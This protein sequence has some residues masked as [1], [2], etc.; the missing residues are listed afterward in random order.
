MKSAGPEDGRLIDAFLR[1]TRR[2]QRARI[3]LER[4]L[5]L[6]SPLDY[7]KLA[8]QLPLALAIWRWRQLTPEAFAGRF[9]SPL[10][11]RV[12]RH[13][14]SPLLYEMITLAE[15]D[16]KRAGYPACGSLAFAR[17]LEARY[18]QLGGRLRYGARVVR[19]IVEEDPLV[20]WD[21]A[22]GLVLR[23][24]TVC[25]GGRVVSAADGHTTLFELLDGRYV[26]ERFVQ[27]YATM[28]VNPSCMQVALGVA[29]Q[30]EG[31]PATVKYILD[32][33]LIIPDGTACESVDV[34]IYRDAPALA[35]DGH[36]LVTARLQTRNDAFWTTTR[37]RDRPAYDAAKRAVA[38]AIIE[39]L[40]QRLGRIRECVDMVDVAS[41]ATYLRYTGNWRG[42][43]RGWAKESMFAC[44]PFKRTLPGLANFY[45]VGQWVTPGGGVP[46]V[47][48]SGRDLAQVICHDDGWR[49]RGS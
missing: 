18:L 49:F 7:L 39:L 11:R 32:A 27:R 25:R 4:P 14:S 40:D 24:G 21:R 41:P 9:Q 37:E 46:A 31:A 38:D 42:S 1:A 15:M 26:S 48:K 5:A 13:F 22:V 19:I 43:T 8:R 34:R 12:V 6:F 20:P 3:P 10:L 30:L 35:P 45:M 44:N 17:T 2:F 47:Y 29:R 16:Q 28:A 33:P 23:D 36:T